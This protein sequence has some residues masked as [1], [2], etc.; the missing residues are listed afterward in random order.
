MVLHSAA[1]NRKAY[2]GMLEHIF[3]TIDDDDS[4]RITIQEFEE[5]FHDQAVQSFL[6]AVDVQVDDAWTLFRI[7][8]KD[9]DYGISVEEFIDGCLGMRGLAKAID[10]AGLRHDNQ[11]MRS[12]LQE[13]AQHVNSIRKPKRMPHPEQQ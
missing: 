12:M 9:N 7:L 2:K 3:K 4:G 5:H 13:L 1:K 11:I 10:V 8:D 6:E